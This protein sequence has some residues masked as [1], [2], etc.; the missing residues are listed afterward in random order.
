[1]KVAAIDMG[2]NT[3]L[4]LVAEVEEK[5]IVKV[6][7]DESTVTRLGQELS[8]NGKLHAEALQ[9]MDRCLGEYQRSI[10]A[11]GVEKVL[12]VATSAARDASNS[13]ELYKIAASYNIPIHII[14]GNKEAEISF[15]GAIYDRANVEGIAVVDVGGGSTE[16]VTKIPNGYQSQSLNIGSVRL[17]DMFLS[18]D[19]ID[20]KKL[21]DLEFYIQ[22]EMNKF[23]H[24]L[25]TPE[26]VQEVVAV[27]G[28][29][30]TL[31]ML[32]QQTNF[33]EELIHGHIL[34]VEKIEF[35]KRK[36]MELSLEERRQIPG[37]PPKRADVIVA[38][39]CILLAACRYLQ[40]DKITVS[41][42]GVR[43][44]LAIHRD[45]F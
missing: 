41:T 12:S 37:M 25:P 42:K 13:E 1:M 21:N 45:Q 19:P 33:T 28:T 6:L 5:K 22:S 24:E 11:L 27:A 29:P 15:L 30:T 10:Q 38:G 44:G 7:A 32:D 18:K 23:K 8:K 26:D 3:T 20:P 4:M 14:D 31:S 36:L 43:Y 2:T 39:T 35:W 9:R 40:V 16:L 17:N 34:S